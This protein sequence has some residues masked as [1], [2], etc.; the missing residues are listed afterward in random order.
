M[1]LIGL[2][3]QKRAELAARAEDRVRTLIENAVDGADVISTNQI[4][5]SIGWPRT[6]GNARRIAAVMRALNFVPV[7]SR[8]LRQSVSGDSC[9]RGWAR[10]KQ[11][12]TKQAHHAD[13]YILLNGGV[14]DSFN[15]VHDD[16]NL[17][18]GG[19]RPLPDA[20]FIV[21]N[22]DCEE[23]DI[24]NS[25]DEVIP[26]IRAYY[27]ANPP[28]WELEPQPNFRH[29]DIKAYGPRYMKDS[30]FGPL[31]VFQIAPDQWVAYRNE[32][33]LLRDG[34][35][36]TFAAREE[37]QCKADAHERDGY[38]NSESVDDGYSWIYSEYADWRQDPH[39]VANRARLI[40]RTNT[41]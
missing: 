22:K 13:Q 27:E 40:V 14:F 7:K 36:A 33:E 8:R 20:R 18:V 28:R 6:T 2:T 17:L 35:I 26:A 16:A 15:I 34:K 24:V 31:I 25:L 41:H 10:A 23:V 21:D 11:N 3:T 9:A 12:K 29:T 32:C 1:N 37:A 19:A 38:P 4:L 5:Q 30:P 39:M